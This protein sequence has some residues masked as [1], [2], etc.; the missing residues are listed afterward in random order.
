MGAIVLHSGISLDGFFEGPDADISWHRV[1]AELHQYMN[2]VLR[3]AAAFLEGRVTYQLMEDYWPNADAAPDSTPVEAEFAG[4]WRDT[5]KV[6]YS[7][8]LES[9]GPNATLVRDVVPDEVRALA[10]RSDGELVVGGAVLRPGSSSWGWSTRCASTCTPSSSGPAGGC[11]PTAPR[12]WTSHCA[13][14]GCSATAS[15]CS[16]TPAESR[17]EGD[18]GRR[19]HRER[20]GARAGQAT[21][22]LK[23]AIRATAA[24]FAFD[25]VCPAGRM[26]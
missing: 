25:P 15:S 1:D 19:R 5:P 10:A 18:G 3:P 20:V 8:T 9:V 26:R 17:P 21:F 4:V 24:R 2:D 14:A 6:V 11:S 12:R 16:T 23:S 7:R 22:A 13:R